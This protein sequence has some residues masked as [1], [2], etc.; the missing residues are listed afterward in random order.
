MSHT[1]TSQALS[2]KPPSASSPGDGRQISRRPRGRLH[3]VPV[4]SRGVDR[5]PAGQLTEHWNLSPG[6]RLVASWTHLLR[7]EGTHVS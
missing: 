3:A 7:E 5:R 4:T 1:M 6:G 2:I